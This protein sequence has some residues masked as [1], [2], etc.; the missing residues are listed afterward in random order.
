MKWM[1]PCPAAIRSCSTP[2]PAAPDN[3][4]SCLARFTPRLTALNPK[5]SAAA[6]SLSSRPA[7]PRP[8]PVLRKTCLL[9]RSNAFFRRDHPSHKQKRPPPRP[10]QVP[11]PCLQTSLT[12]S[13][14]PLLLLSCRFFLVLFSFSL[15]TFSLCSLRPLC[16]AFT[17]ARSGRSLR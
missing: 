6:S 14:S 5:N 9:P 15:L 10:L 4:G 17:P 13:L 1:W 16:T 11:M 12:L 2:P 3:F 8:I 7:P